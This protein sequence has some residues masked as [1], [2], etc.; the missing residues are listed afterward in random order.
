MRRAAQQWPGL[1]APLATL[2]AAYGPVRY[3]GG[4]S[5]VEAD[6][7][8]QSAQVVLASDKPRI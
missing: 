2:G 6:Q 8:E 4:V 5:S 1:A 3:G 7:A